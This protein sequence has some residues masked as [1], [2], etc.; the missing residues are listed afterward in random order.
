M[1]AKCDSQELL[2]KSGLDST[3]LRD[4]VLKIFSACD[5][6]LTFKNI[7]L[8]IHK[9]R[10]IDKVTLYR[11]L[12]LFVTKK[13]FRRMVTPKGLMAFEIICDDHRP[14]HAHFI[15]R[16]CEKIE[17]LSDINLRS[18]R[19]SIQKKRHLDGEEIDLK[20]EGTCLRCRKAKT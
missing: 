20:L 7:L 4:L 1:N 10:S 17:C 6:A 14:L 15:C 12:D 8:K 5:R 9:F 19:H 11:I 18:V 13:I 3:E 2:K 16:D